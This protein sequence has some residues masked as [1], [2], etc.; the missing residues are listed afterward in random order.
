MGFFLILELVALGF[1]FLYAIRARLVPAV[2]LLVLLAYL[3]LAAALAAVP[4]HLRLPGVRLL[5]LHWLVFPVTAIVL[6]AAATW[7]GFRRSAGEWEGTD[8]QRLASRTGFACL[9]LTLLH[10]AGLL[11]VALAQAIA[12]R[13]TP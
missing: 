13:G 6:S 11:L 7:I 5:D 10:A 9:G 3:T 12:G 2:A 4:P 1:A 8:A